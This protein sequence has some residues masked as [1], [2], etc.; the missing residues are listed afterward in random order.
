MARHRKVHKRHKTGPY[1]AHV[2][3]NGYATVI[4]NSTAAPVPV[5]PESVTL[6]T[7]GEKIAVSKHLKDGL[8]ESQYIWFTQNSSWIMK[9]LMEKY[10]LTDYQAAGIMGNLAVESNGLSEMQEQI[11]VS[12]GPGGLGIAQWTNSGG[13]DR[14][15][16]FQN[17]LNDNGYD[18]NNLPANVKYLQKDI[19]D[20]YSKDT[21]KHTSAITVLKRTQ[22]SDDATLA[23]E[24]SFEGAPNPSMDRRDAAASEA[25]RAYQWLNAPS[26]F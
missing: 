1:M 14:R 19:D 23:W 26:K 16:Q 25:L 15:T 11:P 8:S 6:P 13:N 18:A 21:K 22:N 9:S 12:K 5:P 2:Y 17:W 7:T 24:K 20:N 3:A 4:T 10:G